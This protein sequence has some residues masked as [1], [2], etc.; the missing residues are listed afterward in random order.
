MVACLGTATG[1][2][3]EDGK[4]IVERAQGGCG[5][6]V[7]VA[8][9]SWFACDSDIRRP[10][11]GMAGSCRRLVAGYHARLQ[12]LWPLLVPATPADHVSQTVQPA[13]RRDLGPMVVQPLL[14]MWLGSEKTGFSISTALI[15]ECLDPR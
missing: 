9:S 13:R 3:T 5:G 2:G 6:A 11:Q 7:G 8:S 15:Q 1:A 4:Q 14:C 10:Q 12:W